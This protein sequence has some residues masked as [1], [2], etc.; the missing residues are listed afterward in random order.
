MDRRGA[1]ACLRF[2]PR[3]QRARIIGQQPRGPGEAFVHYINLS[4][5]RDELG[6]G[7]EKIAQRI[8]R[9][10]REEIERR[11]E[12][13]DIFKRMDGLNYLV[14][15]AHM[16]RP[17]AQLKCALIVEDIANRLLGD[18]VDT[19]LLEVKTAILQADGTVVLEDLP[20]VAHLAEGLFRMQE[21]ELA[22][23]A[24]VEESPLHKVRLV[25]RPIWDV[26]RNT[27][28]TYVCVPAVDT[29]DGKVIT[30][31]AAVP[32]IGKPEVALKL[33]Q[34]VAHRVIQDLRMLH[35][36]GRK[37][38]LIAPVHFE[39]VASRQRC[40]AYIELCET[41]PAHSRNL[42]IFELVGVPEKIPSARL[43]ELAVQFRR[44]SRAV[45]L[46]T[47]IAGGQAYR[48]AET[49]IF[50]IGADLSGNDS[51][52]AA[53]MRHMERLAAAATNVGLQSYIHGI[54]SVSLT[55]AAVGA[56]FDYIDGDIINSVV[57]TP[58][59]AYRFEARNIYDKPPLAHDQPASLVAGFRQ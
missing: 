6:L 58:R 31:E 11:L 43:F 45:I 15:F 33:D 19:N 57:D 10:A 44:F 35:S 29:A 50:A 32:Q 14:L 54:G 48:T 20:R 26:Q 4:K 40:E 59:D 36:V 28:A 17:Q 7:W 24:D 9:I 27:L 30:G 18:N 21:D 51:S 53:L 42:V 55:T 1:G 56:G 3:S 12:T 38:L 52:E 22:A 39:T 37:L 47:P 46:R 2:R 16:T 41:I 34:L 23:V 49:G 5:L 8:D 25:Y 13:T